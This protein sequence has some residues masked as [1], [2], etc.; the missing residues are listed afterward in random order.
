MAVLDSAT[1]RSVP[2]RRS[3]PGW[4]PSS[5][6]S[7]RSRIWLMV[8]VPTQPAASSMAS[9]KPSSRRHTSAT[10][11]A[12]SAV[13][14]KPGRRS[15][16]RAANSRT[17]SL[18]AI[19]CTAAPGGGQASRGTGQT[20]SPDTPSTHR[21]VMTILASGT[22]ARILLARSATPART[23]SAPSSTSRV[24]RPVSVP[25]IEAP[26]GAPG[27]SRTPSAAATLVST[28]AAS[29]IRSMATNVT[30]TCS[31]SAGKRR[32]TSRAS[33]V[34]PDPPGPT[35]DSSRLAA[36]RGGEGRDLVLA[37][38]EGRHRDRRRARRRML[39]CVRRVQVIE[40]P[41][42]RGRYAGPLFL[43][44]LDGHG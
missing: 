35:R 24:G 26:A 7:L 3:S 28:S 9:G 40:S 20:C 25:V 14:S 18:P 29:V 4:A 13:I 16:A 23:C 42:G 19:A 31:A 22:S 6:S 36:S 21:L 44:A 43:P 27:R 38:D 34:F 30:W 17:A 1:A 32:M 41:P 37:A 15:A 2:T 11:G 12:S 10:G 5:R 39:W 33:R 8:R